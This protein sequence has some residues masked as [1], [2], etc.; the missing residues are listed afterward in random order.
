MGLEAICDAEA[1]GFP[2]LDGDQRVIQFWV[3]LLPSE[4]QIG[5]KTI[6]CD[7][8]H[9][10]IGLE[11]NGVSLDSRNLDLAILSSAGKYSDLN[12]MRKISS[13]WLIK[14]NFL[15]CLLLG[16]VEEKGVGRK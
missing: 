7:P 8:C 13:N 2:L 3:L 12:N 6:A 11:L 9:L 5:V 1:S 14:S 10:C 15:R 4:F 16:K